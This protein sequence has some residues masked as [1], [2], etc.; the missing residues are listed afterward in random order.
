MLGLDI[1]RCKSLVQKM[2]GLIS[3]TLDEKNKKLHLIVWFVSFFE[4]TKKGFNHF[5]AQ[6]FF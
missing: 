5:F 1:N 6:F 4:Y 2:I 3:W